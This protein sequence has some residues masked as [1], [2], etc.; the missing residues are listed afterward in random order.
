VTRP[1]FHLVPADVW[2]A[3]DPATPYAAASLATEGFV[4]CTDGLE[5]LAATFERH[6]GHDPRPFVVLTL[7]LD[8][9][10]APWL[11]D[12]PGSPYP[13]VYGLIARDAIVAVRRVERDADG[14]FMGITAT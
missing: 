8:A 10:D 9:L 12:D 2:A 13:H 11:F 7:D 14:R 5:A 1:T 6:Y 3:T 4:H